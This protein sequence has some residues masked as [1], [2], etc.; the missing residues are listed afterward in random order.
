MSTRIFCVFVDRLVPFVP[1]V[2]LLYLSTLTLYY[3]VHFFI[4]VYDLCVVLLPFVT[5]FVQRPERSTALGSSV[6]SDPNKTTHGIKFHRMLLPYVIKFHRTYIPAGYEIFPTTSRDS[7]RRLTHPK[8]LKNPVTPR[9]LHSINCYSLTVTLC[10]RYRLP[11]RSLF[12]I[13]YNFT[14]FLCRL[15]FVSHA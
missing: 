5:S 15:C 10:Q 9:L 6:F 11:L 4:R 12:R 2:S 8:V 7:H 1:L 14:S 3:S 13:M